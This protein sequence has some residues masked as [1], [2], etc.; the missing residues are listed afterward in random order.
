MSRIWWK[1][2]KFCKIVDSCW[3]CDSAWS[4][5]NPNPENRTHCI[6]CGDKEGKITGWVWG[7]LIDPFGWLYQRNTKRCL[8][9]KYD[10]GPDGKY[11]K[12]S[13]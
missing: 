4:G 7:Y 8:L 12:K 10:I 11:H 5:G 9:L 3:N 1:V 2:L 6:F 13:V